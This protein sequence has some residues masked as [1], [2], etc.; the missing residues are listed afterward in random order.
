MKENQ[1][2]TKEF[3]DNSNR[4]LARGAASAP[5]FICP[6]SWELKMNEKMKNIFANLL[7]TILSQLSWLSR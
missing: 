3:S 2:Q 4:F 5:L 1:Q 7:V 6:I